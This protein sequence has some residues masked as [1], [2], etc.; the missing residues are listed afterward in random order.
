MSQAAPG[1][2]PQPDGS[3]RY[4]DGTQW[5]QQV[6]PAGVPAMAAPV[7]TTGTQASASPKK[8][9]YKRKRVVIPTVALVGIV[10]LASSHGSGATPS[11]APVVASASAVPQSAAATMS[12]ADE[13]SDSASAEPSEDAT[14]EPSADSSDDA[15]ADSEDSDDMTVS[16]EQAVDKAE[17]YIDYTAFSRTGLIKQLK[18]EGFSTSDSKFA[19]DHIDV[20]WMEQAELKA[21]Q[22][23]DYTS[24]S[25][26]GL[27][28]QLEF[29]G[30][31]KKQAEHGA[32]AAGL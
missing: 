18:Y 10:A 4:W 13:E 3:R 31:T 16:Q 15:T 14:D 25:R 11:A 24:F 21:K 20:D 1:W 6:V 17:E 29:E 8:A 32:K 28:K 12:A 22:Y 27:I 2:Y 7:V 26:R 5:T 9:W 19:V 23:L 30:F